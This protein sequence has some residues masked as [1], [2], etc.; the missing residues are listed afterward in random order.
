M[1]GFLSSC[2]E[3]T[4]FNDLI[5]NIDESPLLEN[6]DDDDDDYRPPKAG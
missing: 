5:E 4:T 3:D 2:A 1:I 6:G